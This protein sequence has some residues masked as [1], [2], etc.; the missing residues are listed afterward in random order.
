MLGCSASLSRSNSWLTPL[1]RVRTTGCYERRPPQP[2]LFAPFCVVQLARVRLPAETLLG[3][4][5]LGFDGGLLS[6]NPVVTANA[7]DRCKRLHR[8]NT[9]RMA[10]IA[11][12]EHRAEERIRLSRRKSKL[13]HLAIEA[14]LLLNTASNQAS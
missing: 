10:A 11:R 1:L 8:C 4:D 3:C 14:L 5:P 9:R 12:R 2:H 7:R 13:S 6:L